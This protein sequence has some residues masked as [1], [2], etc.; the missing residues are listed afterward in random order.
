MTMRLRM[1]YLLS[2]T[3]AW[4]TISSHSGMSLAGPITLMLLMLAH[5]TDGYAVRFVDA[6]IKSMLSFPI[7]SVASFVST[8]FLS[9]KYPALISACS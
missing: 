3:S 6:L 1:S 2:V 7:T 9:V 5:S 8:N 4:R